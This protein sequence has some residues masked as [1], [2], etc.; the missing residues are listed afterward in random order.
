MFVDVSD[1]ESEMGRYSFPRSE[2]NIRA[3]AAYRGATSDCDYVESFVLLK[4]IW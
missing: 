3:L 4:E 2:E 1:Y